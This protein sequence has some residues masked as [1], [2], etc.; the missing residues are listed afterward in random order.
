MPEQLASMTNTG[1][2]SDKSRSA[3]KGANREAFTPVLPGRAMRPPLR[4]I[5]IFSVARRGFDIKHPLFPRLRL[6]G[7]E[8]GERYVLCTSF[9]DPIPQACPDQERGGS[10]IDDNDGWIAAIDMLNPGNFTLD[11]YHG[12]SNP[13]F[14]ANSNGTNLIAE[15]I[16]PSENEKPTEAELKR[17]EDARD[18]HWRYLA[19]EAQRLFALGAKQG[20]EF[21]QRYPD[22][23]MAMDALSISAS[24]HT[25]NEI[26]SVCPNCGDDIRPGIAFHQSSTGIL[27]VIDAEKA[28]KAGAIS[29]ERYTEMTGKG[30]AGR[31][32]SES[33]TGNVSA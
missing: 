24:W 7:C 5:H 14:F 3:M 33:S 30:T 27:C 21:L 28:L 23:H 31:P 16:F 15:G 32:K 6:R 8:N 26:K 13:S 11:P 9:G 2:N 18:R 1:M 10:R 4:M 29:R 12:A 17:A 19:R 25:L 20:N 22:V